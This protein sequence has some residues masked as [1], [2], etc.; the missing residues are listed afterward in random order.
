VDAIAQGARW[1]LASGPDTAWKDGGTTIP[2]VTAGANTIVFSTVPG[3]TA[4]DEI[5]ISVSDGNTVNRSA[6]Y[7]SE[8]SGDVEPGG[9]VPGSASGGAAA[10]AFA[11][12][13]L[14]ASR[15]RG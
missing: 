15:R 13:T 7:V 9:C 14:C 2:F 5:A 8:D 3:W 6:W 11:L 12:A 4:P 10:L 1:R